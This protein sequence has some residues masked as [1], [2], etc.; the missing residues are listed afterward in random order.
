LLW[1]EHARAAR[2]VVLVGRSIFPHWRGLPLVVQED[3]TFH[4]VLLV[5]GCL[6]WCPSWLPRAMQWEWRM[7]NLTEEQL[8]AELERNEKI[9]RFNN[10]RMF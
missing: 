10:T 7:A 2:L 9:E 6:H 4:T 1:Q 3:S 5:D 8:E